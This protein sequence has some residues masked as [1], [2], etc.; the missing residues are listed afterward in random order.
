MPNDMKDTTKQ[1]IIDLKKL[2]EQKGLTCQK[3]REL[4]EQNG[5]SLGTTTIR[6][7]FAPDSENKANDFRPDTLN[8]ILHAVLG[9]GDDALS[10]GE[11]AALKSVIE[12]NDKI[13][14]E[15]NAEILRLTRELEDANLRIATMADMFRLAM[16]SIGK[17]VSN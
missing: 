12:M 5:E 4:C 17:S 2:K 14:A 9:S 16:E 15:K 1:A 6:R 11:G 13:L 3:I 10:K 8:A 7:I